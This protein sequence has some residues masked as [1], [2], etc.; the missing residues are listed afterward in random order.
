M[1]VEVAPAGAKAAVCETVRPVTILLVR[2][3]RAGRRDRWVGDDRLRP[4][5]KKGRAQAAALPSLLVPLLG[6]GPARLLS[7]PWVRCM[8]TLEPLAAALGA[9]VEPDE[10]LAEGMGRD[11]VDAMGRW[12]K[13][14][15][16]VL[17]THGDVVGALL[18]YVDKSGVRVRPKGIPPK[19]SV[20]C[21][22]GTD[23]IEAARY[24][25]PPA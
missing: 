6:A 1:G 23:R 12:Q 8:E 20:W 7:S 9:V 16:V 21:F 14:T 3:A 22:S 10:T 5:S 19:G 25:A 11:A 24:F 2:H 13:G 17:C 18:A 4:L 15:T